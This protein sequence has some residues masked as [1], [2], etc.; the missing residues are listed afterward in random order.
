[1][2]IVSRFCQGS[3]LAMHLFQRIEITQH[4]KMNGSLWIC[5][6][7]PHRNIHYC[8]ISPI[9]IRL[10]SLVHWVR[11]LSYHN[12]T[13]PEFSIRL[14]SHCSANLGP[15]GLERVRPWLPCSY[16]PKQT[17]LWEKTRQVPEQNLQMSQVWDSLMK[18]LEQC[19]HQSSAMSPH[20]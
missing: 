20:K 2:L 16:M 5:N 15:I 17:K 18:G 10:G 1:M 9:M 8:N 13:T 14:R 11:L 19:H 12:Q 3:I 7:L 6:E 4:F